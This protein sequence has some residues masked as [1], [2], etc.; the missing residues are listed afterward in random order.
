LTFTT[1]SEIAASKDDM[2]NPVK[3]LIVEDEPHALMG[4]AELI[5]GW[6]Y[7]TETAR[8]GIEGWE[9]ALAWD[10]AIVITDL[11]MPRMDGIGLLS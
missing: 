3:V 11:K 1:R 4:L 2:Q 10:P 8:D 5:S 7:E 9:K 6:G